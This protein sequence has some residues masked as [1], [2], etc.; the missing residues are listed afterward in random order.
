MCDTAA[1][2]LFIMDGYPAAIKWYSSSQIQ[3]VHVSISIRSQ[4]GSVTAARRM[5][6]GYSN[7]Q[8]YERNTFFNYFKWKKRKT[9]CLLDLSDCQ[10]DHDIL[11]AALMN[12]LTPC[13]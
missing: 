11:Q 4:S 3:L 12:D 7:T 8:Q 13:I 10:C 2:Y 5:E 1:G 9:W 6:R